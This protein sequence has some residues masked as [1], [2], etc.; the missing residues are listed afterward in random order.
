VE[1][2]AKLVAAPI[3]RRPIR[4][5]PFQL[6][7]DWNMLGLGAVLTQC[8]DEGKEFVVAYASRSNNAAESRYNSYEGECLAAVWAVAHFRCYLFGTQFTLVTDHQPL[9]WLMESD[10]LIGKLARWALIL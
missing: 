1:L 9:K 5:H 2:K 4:G 7:T 6:H 8:D 10:K 3:L